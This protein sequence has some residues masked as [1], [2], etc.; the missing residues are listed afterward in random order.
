[1]IRRIALCAALAVALL[2]GAPRDAHAQQQDLRSLID[3]MDRLQ[4]DM[5]VM[6]RNLA[7]GTTTPAGGVQAAN[8]PP[9]QAAPAG[10]FVELTD[11]RISSLETQMREL[12]GRVEET[13]NQVHVTQQKLDKLVGDVDFRLNQLEKGGAAAPAAA[14]AA[15]TPPAAPL[16]TPGNTPPGKP[17]EQ[18][19]VLVP[20][21]PATAPV[22]AQAAAAGGAPAAANV[23]LPAGPPETQYE[24]AYGLY[25]QAVQDRGDFGR[26]ENALR[27]FV[28][29][30]ATHR[31]A[32]DAQYWLGETY[33]ARR[34]WN[35]A[36]GAFAEQFKRFPQNAK[37][38]DS[39]LRLGQSLGQLNRKPDACGTLAELAK[40]YPNASQSIKLAAQRERTRLSCN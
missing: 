35:E 15:D 25:Q 22:P 3:R 36:A 2:P 11:Q 29:A 23:T 18:K 4:R 34:N 17:G 39:L 9:P 31:L 19:L 24:F 14:A 27:S 8:S 26:A 38:P 6:Q 20:G 12:T 1:M 7:R 10:S 16:G 5:D 40:R 33:Y 30:N 13:L 21:Q 32:G 37:A 28:A